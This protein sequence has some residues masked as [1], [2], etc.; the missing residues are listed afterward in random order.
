MEQPT[1]LPQNGE[2]ERKM[3]LTN[4]T[5]KQ[6]INSPK[7]D[8]SKVKKNDRYRD[9]VIYIKGITGGSGKTQGTT[10]NLVQRKKA[11]GW[12]IVK[13]TRSHEK[14]SPLKKPNICINNIHTQITNILRSFPK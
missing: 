11:D 5:M 10:T 9:K 14:K 1:N 4:T 12:T 8:N 7:T 6:P 13:N 3:K 2:P